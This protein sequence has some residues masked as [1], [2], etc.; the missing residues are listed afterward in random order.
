MTPGERYD[1][2]LSWVILL[3][4]WMLA[5]CLVV[6]VGAYVIDLVKS[7]MEHIW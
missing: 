2:A 5:L 7:G 4:L 6:T 1:R 3:L